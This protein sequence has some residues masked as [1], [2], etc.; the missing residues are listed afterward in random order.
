M[1]T[2]VC[3]MLF[4]TIWSVVAFSTS[5]NSTTICRKETKTCISLWSFDSKAATSYWKQRFWHSTSLGN[6]VLNKAKFNDQISLIFQIEKKSNL[7][8]DCVKNVVVS[9]SLQKP[10]VEVCDKILTKS[11][12]VELA[13]ILN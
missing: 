13:K 1:T 10:P 3:V 5:L 4:S 9:S 2:R 7:S 8:K 11:E 12:N 6:Q